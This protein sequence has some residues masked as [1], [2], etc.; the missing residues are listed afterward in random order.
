MLATS[1]EPTYERYQ[2]D[3]TCNRYMI[4]DDGEWKW[5][6]QLADVQANADGVRV[7]SVR[8]GTWIEVRLANMGV[9]VPLDLTCR[10]GFE[11]GART[12]PR[13]GNYME[14]LPRQGQHCMPRFCVREDPFQVDVCT[15]MG[16][17]LGMRLRFE[18]LVE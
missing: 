11:R 8:E 18:P 12:Q 13:V 1:D 3:V 16:R 9:E 2:V 7:F 6:G 4:K 14:R 5:Q 15:W 10:T 17:S